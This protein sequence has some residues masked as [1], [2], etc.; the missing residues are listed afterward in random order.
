[1]VSVILDHVTFIRTKFKFT[2]FI[3]PWKWSEHM[4]VAFGTHIAWFSEFK[5]YRSYCFWVSES[6]R[7]YCLV[8]LALSSLKNDLTCFYHIALAS[9]WFSVSMRER[10]EEQQA[11]YIGLRYPEDCKK[12]KRRKHS[13][14]KTIDN[15][16]SPDSPKAGKYSAVIKF[17]RPWVL[18]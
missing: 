1:M 9:D 4:W 18:M 17:S 13:R 14:Q 11:M 8:P 5:T 3:R 10:W 12:R 15:A 6:F 2:S 7:S 16:N